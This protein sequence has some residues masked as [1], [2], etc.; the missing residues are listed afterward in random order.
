MGPGAG[1]GRRAG[2]GGERLREK[3][4]RVT[5]GRY[6]RPKLN[7]EGD[8]VGLENN[9]GLFLA[10]TRLG[11]AGSRERCC[12]PITQLGKLRVGTRVG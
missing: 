7:W 1:K 2:G 10:F 12:I 9:S 5:W 3:S 11:Q 8:L 6:K 4:R